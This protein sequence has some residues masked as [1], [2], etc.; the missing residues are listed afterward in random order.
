MAY[1]ESNETETSTGGK[2]GI[3]P[4]I[5]QPVLMYLVMVAS[6]AVCAIFVVHYVLAAAKAAK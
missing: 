3:P 2:R 1:T 6:F 5:R 4:W